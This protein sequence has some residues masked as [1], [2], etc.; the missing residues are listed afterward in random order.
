M[1]EKF[2]NARDF[3]LQLCAQHVGIDGDKDQ[4]RHPGEVLCR[5]LRNL[6]GRGEMNE[7]VTNIGRGPD[8]QSLALGHKA[9]SQI[10]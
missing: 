6:S 1:R 3:P 7:A 5:S 4:I 2:A 8:E 10:L 9:F